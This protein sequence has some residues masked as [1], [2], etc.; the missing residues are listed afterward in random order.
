LDPLLGAEFRDP[1]R[2]IPNFDVYL[3]GRDR[4]VL[5]SSKEEHKRVYREA[6][7]VS[8]VVLVQGKVGGVWSARTQK[9]KLLLSIEPFV[10]FGS[11]F[12]RSVEEEAEA[13]ADFLGGVSD[14]SIS[15]SK[16]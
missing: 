11:D 8:A 12:R 9:D 16:S 1:V 15:W 4:R 14:L 5:T 10:K 2:L 13:Y 7:W 6:G 3:A